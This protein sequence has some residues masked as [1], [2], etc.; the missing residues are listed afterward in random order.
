[1][2]FQIATHAKKVLKAALYVSAGSVKFQT[3]ND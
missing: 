3:E 1:M 2:H